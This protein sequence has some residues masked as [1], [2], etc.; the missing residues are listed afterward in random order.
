MD[1]GTITRSK[2]KEKSDTHPTFSLLSEEHDDET[3]PPS[4]D[5]GEDSNDTS[6]QFKMDFD[7]CMQA[8]KRNRAD[9]DEGGDEE[10]DDIIEL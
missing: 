6:F 7:K 1:V 10:G 9:R 3:L 8:N 5:H 4:D 2:R